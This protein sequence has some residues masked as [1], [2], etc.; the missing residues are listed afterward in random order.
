MNQYPHF[1]FV[2]TVTEASQDADGNWS[3]ATESWVLHSICREQSNGK[4]S[5]INGQDGKAIVFAA[6]VHLPLSSERIKEN[7]EVLISETSSPDGFVR[8]KGQVL[9]YDV[10][11]L[12]ERLWL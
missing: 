1:L 10:G 7:A 11:Q 3:T 6:V 8:I 12:H 4:G 9:K 5:V 2:K